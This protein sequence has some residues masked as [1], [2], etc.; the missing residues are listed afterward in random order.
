[1]T[2]GL[3]VC[4]NPLLLEDNQG[5]N[6]STLVQFF[7]QV[8]R[9]NHCSSV[10]FLRR[11]CSAIILLFSSASFELIN[12]HSAR[13]NPLKHVVVKNSFDQVQ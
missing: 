8:C 9:C 13:F 5:I 1:M 3:C 12:F 11:L 4:S 6:D 7:T 2:V 10:T